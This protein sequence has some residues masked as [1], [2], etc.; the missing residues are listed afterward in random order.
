M[1]FDVFI[2]FDNQKGKI[3][4]IAFKTKGLTFNCQLIFEN[5]ISSQFVGIIK[6]CDQSCER[7][8]K[9]NKR[10]QICRILSSNIV[11]LEI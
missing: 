7:V 2:N 6:C 11:L 3:H 9:H 1:C 8:S 4:I 5:E 10:Y